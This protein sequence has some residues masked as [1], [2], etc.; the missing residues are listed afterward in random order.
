MPRYV[1][2]RRMS[3]VATIHSPQVLSSDEIIQPHRPNFKP[4][5]SAVASVT[6]TKPT[7]LRINNAR[8]TNIVDHTR[9]RGDSVLPEITSAPSNIPVDNQALVVVSYGTDAI[10]FNASSKALERLSHANPR[11]AIMLFVEAV[12]VG[13]EPQFSYLKNKGWEYL[14]LPLTSDSAGLF[15]KERLWSIGANKVFQDPKITQCVFIDSDTAF[16]DNSWTVIISKALKNWGF[17]QPYSAIV[18]SEQKDTFRNGT[19]IPS[20]A[21]C[22]NTHQKFNYATPGGAFACTKDFFTNILGG[23]WPHNPVGSGD[24]RFWQYMF[25]HVPVTCVPSDKEES[26]YGPFHRYRIGY[27]QLLLNHYYH[28]PISNRMYV[29]R[30]YIAQRCSTGREVIVNEHGLLQWSKTIEGRLMKA[31]MI[32]LKKNT[33]AYLTIGKAFKTE[34][35]KTMF[36]TLSHM[37][38]GDIDKDHPLY[39]VTYYREYGHITRDKIEA[40]RKSLFSSIQHDFTFVVVTDSNEPFMNATTVKWDL[41]SAKVP[42]GW[43]WM[44]A[45]NVDFGKNAN[46][47]FVHPEISLKGKFKLSRCPENKVYLARNRK[48]WSTRLIYSKGLQPVHQLFR[49]QLLRSTIPFEQIYPDPAAFLVSHLQQKGTYQM[50]DILIHVDYVFSPRKN[51]LANIVL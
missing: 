4:G 27:A 41:P 25:G 48:P 10:R 46:I 7:Q 47:L 33:D 39:V 24:A 34:D 36:K 11:P 15:Q 44:M 6:P 43:E 8:L 40:L 51:E 12:L 14:Q 18:Y 16:H 29:T 22:I 38:F 28:G 30:N 20:V 3:N 2:K 31:C 37:V 13:T 5:T 26:P 9:L 19:P 21:Y 35:T 17:I 42:Y 50:D 1:S 45:L 49:E 23:Q 32:S